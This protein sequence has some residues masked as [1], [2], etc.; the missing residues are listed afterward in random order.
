[1]RLEIRV[2]PSARASWHDYAARGLGAIP[3][4]VVSVRSRSGTDTEFRDADLILDLTSHPA[5]GSWA[6][7]YDGAPGQDAAEAALRAARF[8]L[9]SVVDA[10]GAVRA[11]GRP[12]SEQPG[13]RRAALADVG[14]GTARLIIGAVAGHHF[15]APADDEAITT[16]SH[17]GGAARTLRR[18]LG[19]AARTAYR[20]VYRSPHWRVGWRPLDG[21]DVLT[22]GDLPGQW[23][24]LPDDGYRFFADPFPFEHKG[25]TYLFVED[26]DHR[27]G[28]GVISVAVWD[29]DGPTG[30]PTPVLTH[31]VHLSYPFV[32]EHNGEVWMIPETSGARRIELYR[33]VRFPWE[34]EL[35]SILVDDVEAS[36]ATVFTHEGRWW[37]TATVGYGGS[38][39]D[40]LCLWSAPDL[41][42]PWTPHA[43]NPVLIDIA[44]ARPAGRVENREGRLLRPVQD[45]RKGYGAALAV[46]EITRLDDGGFEQRIVAQHSPGPHWPGRRLHTLNS[47][48]GLE[49]VDGSRLVTKFA[50]PSRRKSGGTSPYLVQREDGLDLLGDEYSTLYERA[51]AS[52]F[53]SGRWL[54]TLYRHLAPACGASPCI[55]TIRATEDGRLVGVLPFTRRRRGPLRLLEYADLGVS[56]YALPVLDR[57]HD[58]RIRAD[59][60]LPGRLRAALGPFD[61]LLV[62]R[63]PDDAGI[64]E[65]LIDG[66]RAGRHAYGAHLMSLDADP[67][68]WRGGLEPRVTRQMDNRYKRLRAKGGFQFRVVTDADE[69]TDIFRA[70]RDFRAARFGERGGRDLL[71]QADYLT[72]YEK[73]ARE[74]IAASGPGSINVLDVDGRP[75]AI[76]FDLLERDRELF[77]VVGYDFA[78]L[79]NLSLGMLIVDQIA[80]DAIARGLK[81]LD[82]TVG[83]EPYKADFGAVRRPLFHVRVTRTPVGFVAFHGREFYLAARRTAKQ[84]LTAWNQRRKQRRQA[85]EQRAK[86]K[87][88]AG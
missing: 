23:R 42:G 36:D 48:G 51:T 81:Y 65:S 84:W 33:A 52:A 71:Q 13:V 11:T 54:D 38:L 10:A 47:G 37:M 30:L 28:K 80:L 86:T 87:P 24:D 63:V 20:A 21:P 77:L 19:A 34:W 22:L 59:A 4:V 25:K 83:D 60:T 40:S 46:A 15:A 8:P 53:Q 17:G 78:G 1:M 57:D 61:L 45:C 76:A 2:D 35:H 27:L 73:V 55:V 75:A 18:V 64:I 43:S 85:A 49:T 12:G 50:R 72:F 74:S 9:V 14:F 5:P 7:L 66:A 6:V 31:D 56:D 58:Q 44:S 67:A 3:D 62:E 29:H 39:S 70:L 41:I 68:A 82:L 26:F 69:V 79:R 16:D 32:L 88:S